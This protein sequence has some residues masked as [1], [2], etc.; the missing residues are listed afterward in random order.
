MRSHIE[1]SSLREALRF[2]WFANETG[3]DNHGNVDVV[4]TVRLCAE[5]AGVSSYS[6][7][8][9]GGVRLLLDL[10]LAEKVPNGLCLSETARR[11][12]AEAEEPTVLN[13]AQRV[14]L[15]EH[16]ASDSQWS[17]RMRSMLRHFRMGNEDR[18]VFPPDLGELSEDEASMITLLQT[19]GAVVVRGDFLQ[20]SEEAFD[21]FFDYMYPWIPLSQAEF[22]RQ[23]EKRRKI[24]EQA[25][26]FALQW[27][28]ERLF[29]VGHPELRSLVRQVSQI[30]VTRG[31]DIRSVDGIEGSDRD[32][33]IEV[34]GSTG[35]AIMFYW[36]A[37]EMEVAEEFRDHYWIYFVPRAHLRR[38]KGRL[39][40]IQDPIRFKGHAFDIIPISSFVSGDR[41]RDLPCT[42]CEYGERFQGSIWRSESIVDRRTDDPI[43]G[44]RKWGDS[45]NGT[46]AK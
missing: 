14:I 18:L 13:Q 5:R 35:D 45:G 22:D 16:M 8:P 3:V 33:Y 26:D 20:I 32:R 23:M 21:F 24:G 38:D 19:I 9:T 7:D 44:S 42:A 4:T 30:D 34:K 39:L 27:E 46:N 31:Y 40:A 6:P 17:G 28:Q 25:E 10:G 37:R 36:T 41:L 15:L 2:L 43:L 29:R 12:C 1:L 11:L